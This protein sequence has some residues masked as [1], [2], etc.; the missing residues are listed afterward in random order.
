[1]T[2]HG[3]P[4]VLVVDDND[5]NLK[6]A[7][8]VLRAA[9]LSTIEAGSGREAILLA[10]EHVPDIVLLDLQLQDIDG[11][12]VARLLADGARTSGIPVVAVSAQ[13]LE[14]SRRWLADAG[15]AGFIEKPLRIDG[16]ADEVRAFLA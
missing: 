1:V 14:T 9:N 12:A 5:R 4:L 7:R 11:A 15:F 13:P 8:D 3:R 2:E 10:T 16:F 6:L